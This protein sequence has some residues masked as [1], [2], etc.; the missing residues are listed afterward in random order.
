MISPRL[1]VLVIGLLASLACSATEDV[2]DRAITTRETVLRSDP[3]R[4]S[5]AVVTLGANTRV[6]IFERQRL[7]VRLGVAGAAEPVRGWLRFTELRFGDSPAASNASAGRSSGSGFAGFSRSVSGFLSSF[8]SPNSRS[9]AR[10]SSTIGIRGLTVAEIETAR[11]DPNALAT[12]GQYAMSSEDA[13]I[14]AGAGGLS[15][16][17][18]PYSGERQ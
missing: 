8:R 11:P 9:A 1:F 15:A 14:F 3:S 2:I 17:H 5:A 6:E 18:V 10:S 12:I 7:W 4:A 16:R 13:E